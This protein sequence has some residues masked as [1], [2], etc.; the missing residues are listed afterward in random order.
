MI[1]YLFQIYGPLY[2]N[3][4]GLAILIGILVFI[5]LA[6]RDKPLSKITTKNQL[7]DIVTIGTILGIIGGAILWGIT[8]WDKL[9]SWLDIFEFWRGGFSILGTIITVSIVIPFYL[10]WKKIPILGFLDRIVIYIPLTQ[11]I[12]RVGCFFAG[13]CHGAVTSSCI[14]VIYSHPDSAAPLGIKIHPT[15]LYSSFLLFLIFLFMYFYAQNR[16][17]K[18]GQLMSLYLI[19]AA[20]ERFIVDFWRDDQEFYI[21]QKAEILSINQFIALIMG[22]VGLTLFIYYSFYRDKFGKNKK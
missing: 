7:I 22:L 18:P 6:A 10:R 2:V 5:S 16:F 3:C 11:A 4:Y 9:D 17:K 19:L 14:G 1:P 21:F 15:Q 12:A 13:C 20:L 8:N